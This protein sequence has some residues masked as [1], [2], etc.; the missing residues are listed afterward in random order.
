MITRSALAAALCALCTLAFAGDQVKFDTS[1][2]SAKPEV[3]TYRSTSKQWGSGFYQVSAWKSDTGIEITLNILTPGYSKFLQGQ[4][5]LDLRPIR[6]K[7]VILIG[8]QVVM[9]S[10][11]VYTGETIRLSTLVKPY[12]RTTGN[13][14]VSK[15]FTVDP[16]LIPILPR[17][18]PLE[19]GKEFSFAALDP[20]K[21][22]LGAYAL[23]VIGEEAIQNIPCFRAETSSFEGKAVV[24]VEKGT[25]H[26]IMKVETPGQNAVHE[27]IP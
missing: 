24:W 23:K 27:L 25:P 18:L 13:D 15:S 1:W 26:R 8:G 20:V 4:L 11:S 5:D 12:N 16:S 17:V 7:G 6:S 9:E 2:M 3:R 10:D 22:A 19:A 21:N 14:L